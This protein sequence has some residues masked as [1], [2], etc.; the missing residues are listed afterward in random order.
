[1]RDGF[2]C[3]RPSRRSVIL[4]GAAGLII[5]EKTWARTKTGP[6]YP[7][8]LTSQGITGWVPEFYPDMT[9][10]VAHLVGPDCSATPWSYTAIYHDNPNFPGVKA[11]YGFSSSASG[12]KLTATRNTIPGIA[13]C[14][15]VINSMDRFYNGYSCSAPVYI[16][17]K[18]RVQEQ[19]RDHGWY[20]TYWMT[21]QEA[22]DLRYGGNN[23]GTSGIAMNRA[24]VDFVEASFLDPKKYPQITWAKNQTFNSTI[25]QNT[26]CAG[27]AGCTNPN[28]YGLAGIRN[29]GIDLWSNTW[30]SFGCLWLQDPPGMT[31]P[32][33]G[34]QNRMDLMRDEKKVW[35]GL[36]PTEWVNPLYNGRLPHQWLVCWVVP[37]EEIDYGSEQATYTMEVAYFRTWKPPK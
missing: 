21:S 9:L 36:P 31:N 27:P 20:Y 19:D 35:S 28:G 6:T 13:N 18:G 17:V 23:A 1:M 26:G 34:N 12:L 14:T 22:W 37:H 33:G 29:A 2:S 16:E 32:P 25:L 11:Q 30:H 4:G 5:P 24:E 3:Y 8:Y 10:P 15:P 7:P